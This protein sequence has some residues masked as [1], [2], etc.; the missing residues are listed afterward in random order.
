MSAAVHEERRPAGR[1]WRTRIP[2]KFS[3]QYFRP[4]FLDHLNQSAYSLSFGHLLVLTA[5]TIYFY[6]TQ[7]IP[8]VTDHWNDLFPWI[9]HAWSAL[10]H[11]H[12][13]FAVPATFPQ[14]QG[15]TATRHAIRDGIL[16]G[17][18]GAGA[19]LMFFVNPLKPP[20]PHPSRSKRLIRFLTGYTTQCDWFDRVALFLHIPNQHQVDKEGNPKKTTA[21]QLLFSPLS[22]IA[23]GI[24]GNV[25]GFGL[26]FG[27]PW[28]LHQVHVFLAGWD[29]A[30][31]PGS[32]NVAVWENLGRSSFDAKM[33]GVIGL[34]FFAR[35]AFLKIGMDLI[36]TLS[37]IRAAKIVNAK[38]RFAAWRARPPRL[39]PAPYRAAVYS[40][41]RRHADAAL[42]YEI[43]VHSAASRWITIGFVLLIPLAAWRGWDILAAAKQGAGK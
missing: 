15:W 1:G 27:I 26:F 21:L 12:N 43:P 28:L 17:E 6:L 5:V 11:G 22:V 20:D 24:P 31:D 18:L 3:G 7:S 42:K 14:E 4:H 10:A 38:T 16:E 32:G 34:F 13:P 2:R 39:W 33:I 19:L 23:S 36:G 9:A 41:V 40:K 8:A 29:V 25:I 35:R 30:P 37:D